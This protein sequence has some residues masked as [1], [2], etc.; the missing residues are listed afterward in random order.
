MNSQPNQPTTLDLDA[1]RARLASAKGPEFWRSLDEIAATPEFQKMVDDEFTPGTSEWSNPVSRRRLMELMGATL[2]LAG[3]TACTRQPEEKIIPYVQAP[4]DVIPGKPLHFATAIPTTGYGLGVLVESH[5]GRPTRIDGNPDHPAS[6]GATDAITQGVALTM[7]DPDRSQAVLREGRNSSYTRFQDAI[8]LLREDLLSTRGAGFRILTETVGSPAL[9]AQIRELFTEI[10]EARWVQYE[11]CNRDSVRAGARLAFGQVVN[12]V[13]NLDQAAVIV[14]LDADFLYS[15]PGAVRYAR[16]FTSRRK[17]AGAATAMNRLYVAEAMPSVTGAKAD[18]RLPLSPSEI[19]NFARALADAVGAGTGPAT[20]AAPA[21]WLKA[22]AADLIANRGAS[23]VVAGDQ[24]PAAVHA[25][26]HAM[27]AALGNVGKTVYYTDPVEPNPTNQGDDFKA[28][29]ADMNAGKVTCLMV[30]GGNPMYNSPADLGFAEAFRKVKLRIRIGEHDDETSAVS[31]WHVPLAHHLE[32][33]GDVRAYDGTVSFQQP[34]IQPLYEGKSAIDIVTLLRDK[35]GRSAMEWVKE[36]WAA[37][38]KEPNFQQVWEKAVHD[39]VLAGSKLGPKAVAISKTLAAD[40]AAARQ[41]AG[42]GVELVF[43]PDPHMYDGRYANNAWLQELPKPLTK[44]TWDNMALMSPKMAAKFGVEYSSRTMYHDTPVVELRL[45]GKSVKAPAWIVPGHADNCVTVHLG[46]GRT[47]GGKIANGVGFSAYAIR[48]SAAEWCARG[49]EVRTTGDEH[50]V[51]VTQDHQSIEG[52]SL[53]RTATLDHYKKDPAF[54]QEEEKGKHLFSLYPD[55]EYKSY[56]W[57]MAIDLNA[58]TGCNAC[59]IACQAENNIPAVGKEQVA[60]GREMHWIRVDRYFGGKS[61]DNPT[62]QHQPVTCM[63]CDN[64][65]CEGVCPV[66][67]TTHSEEGLNQMTYNRCVGTRYC[68]NNCPYKV[69]RFNFFLYNDWDSESLKG[70]RNPDVTVR[71]RGV[72]EKCTYCVQRINAARITAEVRGSR[73][74]DGEVVTACQAVCPT[75]AIHFGD[76]NDP[77]SRIA[78]MKKDER[79][80]GILTDLNTRPRTSYLAG[81]RNP[82]PSLET[83]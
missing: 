3:L 72:M 16:D 33:W 20:S 81:L 76:M 14:S 22:V 50:R 21:E 18:H 66:A 68:S 40:L 4:E 41:S 10:P 24:Q 15:G 70:V 67:A 69:R 61:L 43:R 37:Q 54:A 71:S 82:N 45:N 75:Q 30:I 52:R 56:S 80:Y 44:T 13:L 64:A 49:V 73:I 1:V 9:A 60:R 5:T 35:G 48:P 77:N 46:Y 78:K 47:R 23:L 8:K 29:V 51:A 65:P 17:P 53:L 6:L 11:P 25:L 42:S 63:H 2:G 27:N 83:A 7:W 34:L 31:H 57:G 26:A 38:T 74:Q 55:W 62:I 58:C 36:Y 59:T 19:E 39:G 79:N 28:L 12:T 32:S